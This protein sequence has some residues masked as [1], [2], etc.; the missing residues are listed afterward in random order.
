MKMGT[1]NRDHSSPPQVS[2][3]GRENFFAEVIAWKDAALGENRSKTAKQ[4]MQCYDARDTRLILKDLDSI[5]T[6]PPIPA[7]VTHLYVFRCH[8]LVS[9]ATTLP[10]Q[11]IHLAIADCPEFSVLPDELPLLLEH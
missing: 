5:S 1:S 4:I 8:E 7:P 11:L 10:V 9:F 6:L 2:T 3:S